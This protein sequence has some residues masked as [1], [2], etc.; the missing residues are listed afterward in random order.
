[1]QTNK[2][3]IITIF[4]SWLAYLISYLGRND[5]NACIL[6]IVTNMGITRAAAG[7][8]SSS[9][10]LCN[11]FGQLLCTIIIN[12]VSPITLIATELFTVATINLLFPISNFGGMMILWGINGFI[13]AT[14]LC[15]ITHIFSETLSEPWLSYGSV[16]LNT[17]G[18]FGGMINYLLA[19]VLIQSFNW[20]TVFFTI[21]SMLFILGVVW[22]LIMPKLTA[23]KRTTPIYTAPFGSADIKSVSLFPLLR[24]PDIICAIAAVTVIGSLRE[25][26][27]L[28]I[29]SYMNETFHLDVTLAT[30]ITAFVPMLQVCG[31]IL[32]G[33][34][35]Q[36]I[37][38]LFLPSLAA[39]L[40]SGLCF[41]TIQF[42][43]T[44]N[45]TFPI[46]LFVCNAI[47]MT[48]ALT[49]L[50]SLYPIRR[51]ERT[52]IA[53]LVGIL[54]FFVHLGDFAASTGF[55]WLSSIGGWKLTFSV[56]ALVA[57]SAVIAALIGTYFFTKRG[58]NFDKN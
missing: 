47:S 34:I 16:S 48:A 45:V 53:K 51:I 58:N 42:V 28:W 8:V 7:M 29:P 41:I 32:G 54:N 5:Y 18:A 11:A 57:F 52:Y 55:G 19:P 12:K 44:V 27:S 13:Q 9:F 20:Q 21:S 38:N 2:R 36:K 4:I 56:M 43:P 30:T 6:E 3:Y 24:S 10:A 31:A 22:C 49:F 46:F 15:G 25:S 14:L 33:H 39:F 26:V 40:I 1:M 37:R 17:I 35:G 23:N 50:L